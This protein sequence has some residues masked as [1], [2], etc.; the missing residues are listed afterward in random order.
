MIDTIN[1][2]DEIGGT[3]FVIAAIRALESEKS[4]P[5]FKD[6]F[7]KLF[8]NEA[9]KKSAKQMDENFPPS[10][11]VI[12]FRT[13][14]F[15][16]LVKNASSNGIGQVVLLGG[17]F[18]MRAHRF[19]HPNVTFFEIDQKAVIEYKSSVL[20]QNGLNQPPSV[21]CDY[22]KSNIAKELENIGFE[23]SISS[24]MI[25]EGNT[26]YLPSESIIPFLNGLAE[27]I[28]SLTIAFDFF[29]LDLKNRK[30]NSTQENEAIQGIERAIKVTFQNGYADL[31]VFDKQTPFEIIESN[32]FSSLA[33]EFGQ[34]EIIRNYS[35]DW[36]DILEVYRYCL[37]KK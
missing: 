14:Y 6:S 17:G 37:L 2:I 29:A 25:W 7:A 33:S 10:S 18:D 4:N 12:G 24:L 36:I 27:R 20:E 5:L 21:K 26:M 15:D 19:S 35:K 16:Q 31:S 8:C 1:L 34:Q 22:L 3:A 13:R 32:A 23:R 9:A 28:S 11:T 30:L